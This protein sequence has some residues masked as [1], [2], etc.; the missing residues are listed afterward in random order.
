MAFHQDYTLTSPQCLLSS[1]TKLDS[2]S[3]VLTLLSPREL[4]VRD[5]VTSM[6]ALSDHQA[7]VRI[8]GLGVAVAARRARSPTAGCEIARRRMSKAVVDASAR[9]GRVW[10]LM[11][12]RGDCDAAHAGCRGC[13]CVSVWPPSSGFRFLKLPR[14]RKGFLTVPGPSGLRLP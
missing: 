7:R 12:R 5:S 2:R 3:R 4:E 13:Q 10:Q 14:W 8:Q 6:V 1:T 9:E 11:R